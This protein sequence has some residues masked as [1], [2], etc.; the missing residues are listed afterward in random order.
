MGYFVRHLIANHDKARFITY[1]YANSRKRDSITQFIETHSD[2]FK[3]IVHLDDHELIELIRQDKID[4]LVDLAGHTG[5]S[6]L[7]VFAYKPAPVQISYLGYPNTTALKTMDY[8]ISD[9]YVDIDSGKEFTEQLLV[10]PE[11]FL[12]FGDFDEVTDS[13]PL[14]PRE[15]SEVIFGSFNNLMKITPRAVRLWAAILA[16][17]PN[18]RML[19]KAKGADATVTREH[20]LAEFSRHG[21]APNRIEM[22]GMMSSNLEHRKYYRNVD[23]ALDTF[24]YQ[25]TTT[26]CEALWMRVPVVI[27]AGQLHRQRVGYSI[28]KNAGIEETIAYTEDEYVTVAVKL[29]KERDSL[30]KLRR[31]IH[32]RLRA[33]ILCDPVRFTRQLETT[34][35]QAWS[36]HVSEKNFDVPKRTES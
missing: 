15:D 27:L 25:G 18:S 24:P 22:M 19:I 17:V 31:D 9:P 36:S 23:I 16:Q 33:S 14:S 8:R 5:E 4:I 10:L 30:E 2:Q 20:L 1:C 29:A 32:A 7:P 26:T 28:L 11:C 34:Y 6:R 21:I 12:S 3:T 13:L 35:L